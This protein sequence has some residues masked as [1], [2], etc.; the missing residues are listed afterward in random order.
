MTVDGLQP[1]FDS[2]LAAMTPFA[3][4]VASP[5]PSGSPQV[6]IGMYP[7]NNAE[8]LTLEGYPYNPTASSAL[9]QCVRS[10]L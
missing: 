4:W 10:G 8:D 3:T 6:H 5:P 7:A 2:G 9:Y 1:V